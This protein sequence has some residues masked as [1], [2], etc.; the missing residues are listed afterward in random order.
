MNPTLL[1]PAMARVHAYVRRDGD[2][3]EMMEFYRDC[4]GGTLDAT[5]IR[6]T[7]VAREFP[8]SMQH[9]VMHATLTS[10]TVTLLG[11]DLPDP[12]GHRPG[13]DWAL[14]VECASEPELK[15]FFGRLSAGGTV[16][17]PPA[18]AFWG[19]VFAA[20]TDKFDVDWMLHVRPAGGPP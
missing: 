8:E 16:H 2:C 19:G 17:Q 4:F 7:P 18:P 14:E 12:A 13:N 11:S 3:R 5:A 20:I 1:R 6:D 10:D 9:R 15:R